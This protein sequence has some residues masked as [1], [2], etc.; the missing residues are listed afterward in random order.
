MAEPWQLISAGPLNLPAARGELSNVISLTNVQAYRS[1]RLVFPDLKN[2][3][4]VDSMQIGDVALFQSQ[5]GS[6]QSIFSFTNDARAIQL[7]TPQADSP[8]GEGPENVLDGNPDT[9][10]QNLGKENSG[11]IVTPSIGQTIVTSFEITTAADAISRDPASW[12]L[13][14][15]NAAILSGDFSQGT[16]ETWEFIDSGGLALPD[17][18]L[19]TGAV[20]T[21][22]NEAAYTSYRMVFPTAKS[23]SVGGSIQLGDIQ[24]FGF[25]P[26]GVP[27][28][29]VPEPASIT[30]IAGAMGLAVAAR[31]RA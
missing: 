1:Y 7:P 20:V 14:G 2:F 22:D 16:A 24:F 12:A 5:D 18:R 21:V 3:R 28:A 29:P 9:K 23:S 19:T 31:R 13:Y 4:A 15:T 8:P 17:A 6:G 10:Y 27:Q 11:F 26:P 25:R 30:L